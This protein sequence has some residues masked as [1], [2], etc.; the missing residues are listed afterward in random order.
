MNRIT[1]PPSG[2][3]TDA[4]TEDCLLRH[5]QFVVDQ[6]QSF[7]LA[8][9]VEEAQLLTTACVRALIR[10]A[11]VTLGKRRAI[12][13]V[14]RVKKVAAAPLTKATTTPLVSELFENFFKGQIQ[15][16]IRQLKQGPR[17]T[18]CGVCEAC[19]QQPD[20]GDCKHCRD[21][22]KFG[23]SG[24]SKQCCINPGKWIT[25]RSSVDVNGERLSAGDCVVVEAEGPAAAVRG[26]TRVHVEAA[27]GQRCYHAAWFC[28]GQET[29]LG[30]TADPAELFVTDECEDMPLESITRKTRFGQ[31]R[32]SGETYSVDKCVFL[33]PAAFSL[34]RR[35][36]WVKTVKTCDV[37]QV[38][39]ELYP[40][41]YRKATSYVKG[42]NEETPDPFRIGRISS[43]FTN[44]TG[45]NAEA[46][47]VFLRVTKFYR[48][49]DTFR[50]KEGSQHS[51]PHMIYYSSEE[52]SVAFGHV[53]GKCHVV[54]GDNLTCSPEEYRRCGPHRFYFLEA[55]DADGKSFTEPSPA[56]KRMGLLRKV[57]WRPSG[58]GKGKGAAAQRAVPPP[59]EHPVVAPLRALDVFAGCGGLSAGLHQVGVAVSQ[60]AI[61]INQPAANAYR[62]NNP[63]A[64][65]F[66]EDCN[67]LLQLAIDGAEQNASGQRLPKP[68][69]VDLLCGGP[70]CQGFS[71]MNRFNPRQYSQFK[72]SLIVSFLSFCDFYRPK[73]S[74]L[75]NVRNFVSYKANVV[76]KLTLACLLKMGYQCGFGV[77][78]AGNYG[79][80][81]TRRRA[82]IMASA[83][84][85]RLPLYPEPQHVFSLRASSLAMVMEDTKYTPTCRWSQSAPYRTV[86][87][88]DAM[89]DLP[90]I[91]NGEKHEQMPYDRDANSHFQRVMRAGQETALLRDHVCK[92]MAPLIAAR[93]RH[94]P[95][96]PGSDW[97]DLPN[98]AV[99]LSDGTT[100]RLL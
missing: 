85:F 17:R 41:Y 96:A 72:N 44:R 35:Q 4:F 87:V 67:H 77:L 86:T 11:G 52:V 92:E 40:E 58:Q 94:V 66:S 47:D 48:G 93:I 90:E 80:P 59:P 68:G 31:V 21:M 63:Q 13:K 79:V 51:D 3:G 16:T 97:R 24:R 45:S 8:G 53:M 32:C 65:V 34:R 46:G 91:L 2:L 76:L 99:R 9:G 56:A 5:A 43:I 82:I 6:V 39:E 98:L 50:G 84:G 62:L 15:S 88:R 37:S 36:A 64:T 29:L 49:E 78:Q 22:V 7:D 74:I 23:G 1:V 25:N 18:R 30:E 54:Y 95:T 83:P 75:E 73:Y 28:R 26:P 55:Y 42:S 71:G 14:T 20:C 27:S 19:Q 70:P 60:W 100:S 12:R 69:E 57:R 10:L 81:Q 38:D 89:S 33:D 61:E